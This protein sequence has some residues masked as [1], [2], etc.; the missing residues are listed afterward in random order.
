MRRVVR[1]LILA[2][3]GSMVLAATVSAQTKP[4]KP[5]AKPAAKPAPVLSDSAKEEAATRA[6][7]A[8]DDQF[9]WRRVVAMRTQYLKRASWT[10]L[11]DRCNPGSLRVFPKA[12]TAAQ[13]DSVQQLVEHMEQTIVARGTGSRL[14]TP[15]AQVL[16]RTIVGWEAGIDRPLWDSDEAKPR[17]AVA[18]GFTGEFADP[19]GKGCLPSPMM[20]DTVTFVLPGFATMEF[21]NA[22]KPRVKAYFG[23]QAQ[24]H[25]RDEFFTAVGRNDPES[26]LSYILVAPV[27]I[28]REWALVGVQRPKEK[29][30]VE[31]GTDNNGSAAYLMRRV[32]RQWRLLA[33]VRSGG[34]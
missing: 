2:G 8:E 29:A 15:D 12:L 11:G 19:K 10:D 20:T 33:V 6:F 9:F 14:D 27:V 26:T 23:P 18:A 21:P 25:A 17:T 16:L 31:I 13:R 22:K 7:L 3:A 30:G 28:W 5:T 24:R 4:V 34:S 32:G 1:S